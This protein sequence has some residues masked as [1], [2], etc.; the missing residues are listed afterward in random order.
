MGINIK[1]DEVMAGSAALA[2]QSKEQSTKNISP[3]ASL[4]N[5]SSGKAKEMLSRN[6]I[7]ESVLNSLP[8][9]PLALGRIDMSGLEA[10]ITEKIRSTNDDNNASAIKKIMASIMKMLK[11][12]RN[13]LF[14]S[15]AGLQQL[16]DDEFIGSTENVQTF[17]DKLNELVAGLVR[18]YE[19]N[20]LTKLNDPQSLLVSL[21]SNV[22]AKV[23]SFVAAN[24]HMKVVSDIFNKKWKP[25]ATEMGL[26]HDM[27]LGQITELLN[28]INPDHLNKLDADGELRACLRHLPHIEKNLKSHLESLAITIA[29]YAQ[30]EEKSIN[31]QVIEN[32]LLKSGLSVNDIAH[33]A[34]KMRSG[35]TV[36]V[37]R[38]VA[39]ALQEKDAGSYDASGMD[40]MLRSVIP[41]AVE[42]SGETSDSLKEKNDADKLKADLENLS[43]N[44][45]RN[46][47]SNGTDEDDTFSAQPA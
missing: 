41:P 43:E 15:E 45:H 17:A 28:N 14:G 1:A 11:T 46:E 16:N 36:D 27:S 7:S 32:T 12:I 30:H 4:E 23:S 8:P 10:Q 35:I 24:S 31:A 38:A 42:K 20:S 21:Q 26:N 3:V 25:I 9:G 5:I 6:N 18:P 44:R 37:L 47:V 34:N 22:H 33:S 29:A 13:F 40:A 2:I 39:E 19:I